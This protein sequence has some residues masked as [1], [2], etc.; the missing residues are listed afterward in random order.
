MLQDDLQCSEEVGGEGHR[1]PPSSLR[2]WQRARD[3]QW[4]G[5]TIV[6]SRNA[7][8]QDDLQCSE[9]EVEGWVV[10]AIGRR[11]LDARID[12]LQHTVTIT[13]T[14][15]R[16]FGPQDWGKLASQLQAWQVGPLP[17]RPHVLLMTAAAGSSTQA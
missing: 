13:R 14:T 2:A 9:E 10:K 16:T 11:L 7:C 1:A 8:L 12:Q 5:C 15:Q 6:A 17:E 3:S 4:C